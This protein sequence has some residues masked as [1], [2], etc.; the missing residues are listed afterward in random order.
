MWRAAL[1][2]AAFACASCAGGFTPIDA[3]N[4]NETQ[5]GAPGLFSGPN[6]EF[7]VFETDL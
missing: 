4:P 3:P 1:A 7:T 2:G 5:R 6:G